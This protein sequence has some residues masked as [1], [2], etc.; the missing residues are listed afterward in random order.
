[1]PLNRSAM[2]LLTTSGAEYSNHSNRTVSHPD[3]GPRL[4][5]GPKE[6][7]VAELP[8]DYD[9]FLSYARTDEQNH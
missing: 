2:T 3:S 5:V 7:S 8:G 9:I 4:A 6:D 1:M